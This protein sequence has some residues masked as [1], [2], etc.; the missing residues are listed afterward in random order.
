VVETTPAK[1]RRRPGGEIAKTAKGIGAKAIFAEPQF[2][3]KATGDR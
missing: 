2:S 3:S 1:N